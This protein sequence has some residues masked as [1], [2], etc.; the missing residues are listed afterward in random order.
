MEEILKNVQNDF[1]LNAPNRINN[2]WSEFCSQRVW[3]TNN[4]TFHHGINCMSQRK[5]KEW[6]EKFK[7]GQTTVIN[8]VKSW[9][10][11]TVY[12]EVNERT[13]QHMCYSHRISTEETASDMSITHEKK[14]R[15]NS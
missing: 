8:D 11:L 10:P 1:P 14:N 9:G 4:F 15:K 6:V 2:L 3:K 7:G 5:V 13:V 12:V